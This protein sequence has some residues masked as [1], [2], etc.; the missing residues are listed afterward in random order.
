MTTEASII[1]YRDLEPSWHLLKAREPGNL[2]W[3]TNWVGGA[4]GYINSNPAVAAISDRYLV[5]LM[6][7]PMGN[8]QPGI[9]AHSVTEIYV[10]VSG[11][12][13][14][15]D[16]SGEVHR[17]GPRDCM[18]IPPGVPHGVRSCGD[19]DAYFIWLHDRLEKKGTAV[20]SDLTRTG[21]KPAAMHLVRN[22]DLEPCWDAPQARETGHL[23]WTTSFVVGDP[24]R[25]HGKAVVSERL[26]LGLMVLLPG[27]SQPATQRAFATTYVALGKGLLSCSGNRSTQLDRLDAVYVPAGTA[28]GLRNSSEAAAL[29]FWANDHPG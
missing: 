21:D 11:E 12:L 20:Y 25:T 27:N 26:E 2:R 18:V 1:R 8:R 24:A 9:H 6:C 23:R 22:K 14:G 19:E 5:G 17:A 29:I 28:H 15:V 3:I 13:E 10:V 4:E 7:L 16:G